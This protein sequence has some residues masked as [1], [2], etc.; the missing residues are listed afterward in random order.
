ML[1]LTEEEL[2]NCKL[3]YRWRYIR[4]AAEA[5]AKA[6]GDERLDLSGL[7][8]AP[9]PETLEALKKICGVGVKVANC[10][11]LFGLHHLDAFPVDVWMKRI[12][13]NEY[14]FGYPFERYAPYNGIYQQYMFTY[15]R[16]GRSE[17][18]GAAGK[19]I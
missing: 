5:C 19:G 7:L 15:Y 18:T 10:V 14:P 3:G 1:S 17:D 13:D 8:K 12:L 11:S 4:A 9:E 6:A 16:L 2:I